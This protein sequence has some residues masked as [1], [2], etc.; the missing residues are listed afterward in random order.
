M[1]LCRS[2]FKKKYFP[3]FAIKAEI[4]TEETQLF[5]PS[6]PDRV[7]KGE[8]SLLSA[9]VFGVICLIVLV[10]VAV[11][12]GFYFGGKSRIFIVFGVVCLIVLVVVAVTLGIYFGGKS[13]IFIVFGVV[14]LIVL[15]V[16]AV[17]LGIYF[18]GKS[19]I[20]IVFGVVCLIVLVVVAVTLGK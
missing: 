15:V 16:V 17:T 3:I 4:K 12:L 5:G 11:T 20:F 18:G 9:I 10:V 19:R 2:Y 1:K 14:C 6:W 13:R 8:N 7:F